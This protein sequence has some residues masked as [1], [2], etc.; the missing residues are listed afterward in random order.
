[1]VFGIGFVNLGIHGNIGYMARLG[2]LQGEVLAIYI[3]TYGVSTLKVFTVVAVNYKEKDLGSPIYAWFS[4][5]TVNLREI[6]RRWYGFLTGKLLVFCYMAS[7]THLL[8]S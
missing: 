2:S 7:D 5:A 8:G 4:P 1:M 6:R 3:F